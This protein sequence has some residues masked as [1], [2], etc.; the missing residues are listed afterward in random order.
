MGSMQTTNNHHKRCQTPLSSPRSLHNA[1]NKRMDRFRTTVRSATLR[2]LAARNFHNFPSSS[3]DSTTNNSICTL[4]NTITT[5]NSQND[6][7]PYLSD[8]DYRKFATLTGLSEEKINELHREFLILSNNGQLSYDQYRSMFESVPLQ[9]TPAQLE[10]LARQT[11][12]I[13]DKDGNNYL[14]FAEFIAAYIA[15]ERNELSLA[16]TPLRR[17]SVI[18][19][20]ISQPPHPPPSAT[21]TTVRRHATTY[22]SPQKALVNASPYIPRRSMHHPNNY[23]SYHPSQSLAQYVY[24][25]PQYGFR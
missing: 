24:V 15:M 19:S 23:P 16:D 10:K 3:N 13:F 12:A 5:I 18:P 2:A 1:Q 22:Y 20:S 8:F 25:A 14:D 11:F 7:D 6:S 9:R 17:E 4:P 21:V